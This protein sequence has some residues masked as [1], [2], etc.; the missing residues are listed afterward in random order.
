M[1]LLGSPVEALAAYL[2]TFGSWSSD[3][4]VCPL[5]VYLVRVCVVLAVFAADTVSFI[6]VLQLSAVHTFS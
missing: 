6:S 2:S 3:S 4:R 1:N 5:S